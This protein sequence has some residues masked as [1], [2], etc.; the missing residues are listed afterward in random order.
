MS[1]IKKKRPEQ[2]G[3]FWKPFFPRIGT[4][5]SRPGL[6]GLLILKQSSLP[7]AFHFCLGTRNI[8]T[9]TDWFEAINRSLQKGRLSLISVI[10]ISGAEGS[11]RCSR[12]NEGALG[13]E[14][15]LSMEGR[16]TGGDDTWRVCWAEGKVSLSMALVNLLQ[17]GDSFQ[18]LKVGSYLTLGDELSEE[19]HVLRNKRLY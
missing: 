7:S 2:L 17:E 19:T 4:A 11:L 8:L 13:F 16:Q 5:T 1:K 14:E 6:E 15:A 10:N 12:G 18:G 3:N 9:G